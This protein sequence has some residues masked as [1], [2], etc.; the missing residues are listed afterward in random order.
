MKGGVQD[1]IRMLGQQEM[2]AAYVSLSGVL[3]SKLR[4]QNP[5]DLEAFRSIYSC[6][7]LYLASGDRVGTKR[8]V[9]EGWDCAAVTEE[10][11]NPNDAEVIAFA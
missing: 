3:R 6:K 8:L 7:K 4:T 11:Y 9:E 10:I 1:V 5:H 2:S